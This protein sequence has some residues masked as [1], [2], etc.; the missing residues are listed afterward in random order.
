MG[1]GILLGLF[2]LRV[3][4]FKLP[5]NFYLVHPFFSM[6]VTL[7]IVSMNRGKIIDGFLCEIGKKSTSMWLIHGFIYLYFFK[8]FIY[9]FKYP[10]VIFIVLVAIT[11][12][13]STLIDLLYNKI[14][15]RIFKAA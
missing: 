5:Y 4:S 12:A 11:Y 15:S 10:L 13:V 14:Q 8:D 7:T 6:A 1:G 3:L 9:G 2:V